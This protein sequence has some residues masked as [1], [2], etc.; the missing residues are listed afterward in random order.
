MNDKNLLKKLNQ[1][2]SEKDVNRF[3]H[4]DINGKRLISEYY[5]DKYESDLNKDRRR[6]K[7]FKIAVDIY[8]QVMQE[9]ERFSY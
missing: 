4:L 3:L 5:Y 2:Y 1:I 8:S 9:H 6:T 7:N